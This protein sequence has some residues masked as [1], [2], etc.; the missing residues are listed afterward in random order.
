[1][2]DMSQ[3]DEH[4]RVLGRLCSQLISESIDRIG[5]GRAPTLEDVEDVERR[6]SE[7]LVVNPLASPESKANLEE[8]LSQVREAYVR[9][10]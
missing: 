1:M 8:A 9:Q 10:N 4:T 5:A 7:A 3:Y 6:V 2:V